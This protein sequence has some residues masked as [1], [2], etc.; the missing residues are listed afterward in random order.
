MRILVIEKDARMINFLGKAL[1]SQSIVVDEVT[2]AEKAL[3]LTSASDYD[4]ILIDDL[5]PG[6][7]GIELCYKFREKGVKSPII[8][9]SEQGNLGNV[10]RA[11]D[12]GADDYLVKPLDTSVLFARIRAASRRKESYHRPHIKIADLIIDCNK[13]MVFRNGQTIDLSPK[14]FRLLEFLVKNMGKALT[15][16][17]IMENV[18]GTGSIAFS[19][20]VDVHMSHLRTKVDKKFTKRLIHTVRG[21]GYIFDE[22]RI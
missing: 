10:V 4:V 15:R 11:L 14:E 7:G 1:K 22:N 19:N 20:V 16:I 3:F 17:E 12:S 13:R 18:W 5:L 8:I 9:I 21:G 2:D 6:I